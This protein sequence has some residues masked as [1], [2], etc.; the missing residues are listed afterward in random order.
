MLALL[1][2]TTRAVSFKGSRCSGVREGLA[3]ASNRS[4]KKRPLKRKPRAFFLIAKIS[5][6]SARTA[7][8]ANNQF[9]IRGAN[10]MCKDPLTGSLSPEK[11]ERASDRLGNCR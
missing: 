5:K 2:K 8:V 6:R 7:K 1:S 11:P 10:K 4:A 3:K 9:G